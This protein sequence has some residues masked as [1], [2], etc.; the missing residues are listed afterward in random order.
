MTKKL[1]NDTTEKLGLSAE[2]PEQ[3]NPKHDRRV[4]QERRQKLVGKKFGELTLLHARIRKKTTRWVCQ[5]NCGSLL[6]VQQAHILTGHTKSCGCFRLKT[7]RARGKLNRKHG[8]TRDR[9]YTSWRSMIVRCEHMRGYAD[10]G[11]KVCSRWNTFEQFLADM[12][13]RPAGTTIG[14]KNN[15]GNYEPENCEWQTGTEQSRN[16]RSNRLITYSNR[17]FCLAKWVEIT[18]IPRNTL[19]YR[20][21][22]NWPINR[23]FTHSKKAHKDLP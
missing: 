11:I 12:G 5:C 19:N 6:E 7:S 13:R 20:I 10:R 1:S 23:L 4:W 22:K 14:R 15:D 9:T 17:T 3:V 21:K 2:E 8:L 16:T 18:G